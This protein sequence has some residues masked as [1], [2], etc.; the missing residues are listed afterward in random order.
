MLTYKGINVGTYLTLS[1]S[2]IHHQL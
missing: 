1:W 2:F